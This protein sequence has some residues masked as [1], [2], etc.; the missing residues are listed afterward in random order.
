MGSL[1]STSSAYTDTSSNKKAITPSENV[2][3]REENTSDFIKYADTPSMRSSLQSRQ[4][5]SSSNEELLIYLENLCNRLHLE[6]DPNEKHWIKT[7]IDFIIFYFDNKEQIPS[8][9]KVC[10]GEPT[11]I[12]HYGGQS[13][14]IL[15]RLK[16]IF[17]RLE[18]LRELNM[19]YS[20]KKQPLNDDDKKK[21]INKR[22]N[23]V[24]K[25]NNIV[26]EE[27]IPSKQI[28]QAV[29]KILYLFVKHDLME[30]PIDM[31]KN[32]DILLDAAQKQDY[33]KNLNFVKNPKTPKNPETPYSGLNQLEFS[34]SLNEYLRDNQTSLNQLFTKNQSK[35][36]TPYLPTSNSFAW[37]EGKQVA[38]GIT[39]QKGKPPSS[40]AIPMPAAVKRNRLP[41]DSKNNKLTTIIE[42]K[43]PFLSDDQS[44]DYQ[45]F[46]DKKLENDILTNKYNNGARRDSIDS[47]KFEDNKL[48]NDILTNKYND[49]ARRDS[50]DSSTE[51]FNSEASNRRNSVD[52][53]FEDPYFDDLNYENYQTE[54][55]KNSKQEHPNT[56]N[57]Q[58]NGDVPLQQGE[59]EGVN[60]RALVPLG[61]IEAT[62]DSLLD[63]NDFKHSNNSQLLSLNKDIQ[64]SNKD[65][66]E[67]RIMNSNKGRSRYDYINTDQIPNI[68]KRYFPIEN[69]TLL[70][71]KDVES[72]N[73]FYKQNGNVFRQGLPSLTQGELHDSQITPYS[74]L[75]QLEFSKSL[76]EYLRDNQTDNQTSLNQLFTKN[77]SKA[78]TPYLPTSNSFAWTEGK[79]VAAGITGQ[80]GK[81]PSS[82]A[83]PMPAAAQKQYYLKNDN[84]VKNPETPY[85]EEIPY[86]ENSSFHNYRQINQAPID[87]DPCGIYKQNSIN[88]NVPYNF[89]H[90]R[91]N[92]SKYW[93]DEGSQTWPYSFPYVQ[94][95]YVQYVP[96][97]QT[98][99]QQQTTSLDNIG[100]FQSLKSAISDLKQSIDMNNI[101][102]NISKQ[103]PQPQQVAHPSTF[104]N[105]SAC[106]LLKDISNDLRDFKN[107]VNCAFA[108]QRASQRSKTP[109]Y[110]FSTPLSNSPRL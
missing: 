41:V 31:N 42:T 91:T 16:K 53:Y 11:D 94:Q 21:L 65:I 61:S 70:P 84:F 101:Y 88:S 73:S 24:K 10:G 103:I 63:S 90:E 52:S 75:N 27:P 39:G 23:I 1:F 96:I 5:S 49:G 80:K 8:Y 79:Q 55:N 110:I 4:T 22:I 32:M 87:C 34:E 17:D 93:R 2:S 67:S 46:E 7:C 109:E 51:P 58:E 95:P 40:L 45:K 37:T 108:V 9:L 102:S 47:Q 98:T 26:E 18:E 100:I 64:E 99:P 35:A 60:S 28:F 38:A 13:D 56:D 74:G 81:P 50:I 57:Y 54:S 15:G 33:L 82:L 14:Q 106:R 107:D 25:I 19:R 6:Q 85:N 83:I 3:F 43:E 68:R 66:Q 30:N 71:I 44:K 36:E 62:D 59:L 78:E 89:E 29:V 92:R 77:Q 97:Q 104:D 20:L 72:Y 12:N 105:D 86:N 69:S 76:N 48:E